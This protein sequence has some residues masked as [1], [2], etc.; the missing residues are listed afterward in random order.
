M[1]M[2]M[3]MM[4]TTTTTTMM[5]NTRTSKYD[6]DD[7]DDDDDDEY[8]DKR[9]RIHTLRT[10]REYARRCDDFAP[11]L[12]RANASISLNKPQHD[13]MNRNKPQ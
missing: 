3:M 5:T 12:T 2:M 9:A 1:M 4:M 6:D 8:Q 11:K 10:S 7:D 13:A